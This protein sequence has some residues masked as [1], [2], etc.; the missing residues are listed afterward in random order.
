MGKLEQ[1]ADLQLPS[2]KLLVEHALDNLEQAAD[3]QLP[4][5]DPLLSMPWATWDSLRIYSYRQP[6]FAAMEQHQE[7]E[8]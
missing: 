6:S 7:K 2:G 1:A 8:G 5:A 4:S 3:L